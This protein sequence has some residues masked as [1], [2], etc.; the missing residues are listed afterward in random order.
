LLPGALNRTAPLDD[1][2]V[3]VVDVG[4]VRGSESLVVC[5]LAE[6]DELKISITRTNPMTMG[7]L[8]R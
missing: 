4:C 2:A 3:T 7:C 6:S 5:P 8:I 1:A